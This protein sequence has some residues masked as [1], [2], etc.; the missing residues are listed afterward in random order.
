LNGS[1]HVAFI[2]WKTKLLVDYLHE[3]NLMSTKVACGEGG[4][5]ACTV[6]KRDGSFLGSS[7]HVD[8]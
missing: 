7:G 8:T 2:N 5:G 4:C 1:P 6:L 3:I